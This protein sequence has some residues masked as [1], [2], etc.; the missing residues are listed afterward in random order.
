[1][2]SHRIKY[3]HGDGRCGTLCGIEMRN[4]SG[5]HLAMS[6]DPLRRVPKQWDREITIAEAGQETCRRCQVSGPNRWQKPR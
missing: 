6:H 4:D 3:D 1:M 2:K 5:K